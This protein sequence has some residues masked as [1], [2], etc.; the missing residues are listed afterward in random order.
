MYD[1]ARRPKPRLWR[2]SPPGSPDET[3]ATEGALL[4]YPQEG[5]MHASPTQGFEIL[6]SQLG[7]ESQPA[8][9]DEKENMSED[10]AM[11]RGDGDG[12]VL[13]QPQTAAEKVA[14]RRKMKRFR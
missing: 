5:M 6:S 9:K 2:L 10:E 7:N 13:A 8:A 14:Q 1:E 4:S 11:I 12:E 3:S